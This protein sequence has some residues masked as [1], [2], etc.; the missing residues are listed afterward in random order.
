MRL[1]RLALY[2]FFA[3]VGLVLGN[4]LSAMIDRIPPIEFLAASASPTAYAGGKLKVSFTVERVRPCRAS[5]IERWVRGSDGA[6]Y[7]IGDYTI[8]NPTRMGRET[9][10]RVVRIPDAVP[11]GPAYYAVLITFEC[12][13]VQ[14]VVAPIE[15][16][17]PHI[18]F[19][20]VPA[21]TSNGKPLPLAGADN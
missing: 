16:H 7:G 13:F 1:G 3:F 8:A 6:D 5:A 21:A 12:N 17:S 9:Y 11:L 20:V 14:R 10:T 19:M 4:V 18:E 15:V 2:T